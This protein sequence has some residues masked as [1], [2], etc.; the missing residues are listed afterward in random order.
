[1]VRLCWK[2]EGGDVLVERRGAH[3]L[4]LGEELF[5]H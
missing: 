4:L 2:L 5:L 1:M 3:L